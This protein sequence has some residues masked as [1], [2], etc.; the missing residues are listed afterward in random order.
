MRLGLVFDRFVMRIN[1]V[2]DRFFGLNLFYVTE[3]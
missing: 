3:C 1:L 2:F